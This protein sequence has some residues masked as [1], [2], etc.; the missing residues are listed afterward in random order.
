MLGTARQL[1]IGASLLALSVPTFAQ[2]SK[3]RIKKDNIKKELEKSPFTGSFTIKAGQD[4]NILGTKI[5]T[6]S[7]FFEFNPALNYT[8]GVFSADLNAGIKEYGDQAVSSNAKENSANIALGIN[9]TIFGQTTSST[10][11]NLGYSDAR[12]PDYFASTDEEIFEG[13]G[14][15]HRSVT[16][17]VSQSLGWDL[18]RLNLGLDASH[19]LVDYSSNFSDFTGEY[20][21]ATEFE[22]DYQMTEGSGRVGLKLRENLEISA[23][24]LVSL[25]K[26]D[27]R[28]AQTS[29][30][31]RLGAGGNGRLTEYLKNELKTEL[32]LN[33]GALS[34]GPHI[35]SGLQIDQANGGEDYRYTDVGLSGS[36]VVNQANNVKISASVGSNNKKY[37]N[38]SY[39]L[40]DSNNREDIS[41]SSAVGASFDI[42]KS[43][44]MSLDYSNSE[45]ESN[46]DS[47]D[48]NHRREIFSTGLTLKF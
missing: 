6:G 16:T 46:Y 18:G 39:R 21:G 14:I 35:T 15:P 10:K 44:S 33:A 13:E 36:V 29:T 7:S 34:I 37:D 2:S 42:N 8:Q 25:K 27:N 19:K 43:L 32:K 5:G 22:M 45:V 17:G 1:V 47:V 4:S 26:Y 48:Y 30:G 31:E 12:L 11:L 3:T 23:T 9:T 38:W 40:T 41:S 28:P 24:P 20:K